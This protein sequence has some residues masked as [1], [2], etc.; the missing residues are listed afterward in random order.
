VKVITDDRLGCS[1]GQSGNVM[2]RKP[3][4]TATPLRI[5]VTLAESF[6]IFMMAWDMILANSPLG[7]DFERL[8]QH[9]SGTSTC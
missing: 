9:K 6:C 5:M 2:A 7:K 4:P 8:S 1:L 3:Y